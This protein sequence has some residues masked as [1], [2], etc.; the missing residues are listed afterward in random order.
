MK[1]VQRD[2][3]HLHFIVAAVFFSIAFLFILG[4]WPPS[5]RAAPPRPSAFLGERHQMLEGEI[6]R[7]AENLV[8]LREGHESE[9]L[10]LMAS[11]TASLRSGPLAEA[12]LEELRIHP[13]LERRLKGGAASC[14]EAFRAEH[15]VMEQ[16]TEELDAI[17]CEP[18]PDYHAFCTRGERLL[19]LLEGHLE[20]E[21]A[22]LLPLL[23]RIL[24][25]AQFRQEIGSRWGPMAP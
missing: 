6:A 12:R 3:Y 25:P 23:D 17:S 19:G 22:V 7:L 21:K 9:Q 24:T 5:E 1:K 2:G 4:F 16:W 10:D 13:L 15:R 8:R 14:T 18:F 11:V 20:A